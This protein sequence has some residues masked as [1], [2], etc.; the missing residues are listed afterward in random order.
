MNLNW[1]LEAYVC[2]ECL[3]HWAR[4]RLALS[5]FQC[6]RAKWGLDTPIVLEAWKTNHQAP[7][8]IV[9]KKGIRNGATS[10]YQCEKTN[11][12]IYFLL[13][14]PSKRDGSLFITST[15]TSNRRI[16]QRRTESVTSSIHKKPNWFCRG[17]NMGVSWGFYKRWYTPNGWFIMEN[18]T[19][20]IC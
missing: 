10:L 16:P 17:N 5:T 15:D 8:I 3:G 13:I 11:Q 18:T 9:I 1:P 4:I 19:W 2:Q 20:M 7:S 14:D 12:N 6:Q